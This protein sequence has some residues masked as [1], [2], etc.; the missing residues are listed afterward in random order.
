MPQGSFN[1]SR[2]LR[3]LGLKNII[4]MPVSE[5]IQ[6]VLP[7]ASMLGEVPVHVAG[8]A[9]FGGS[10]AQV[11][12][13]WGVLELQCL[14][15]G[16]AVLLFILQAAFNLQVRIEMDTTP[17]TWLTGPTALPPLNFT[18][19][20]TL[21]VANKGTR[22][23]GPSSIIPEFGIGFPAQDFGAFLIPRGS[24]LRLASTTANQVLAG[25]IAICGIAATEGGD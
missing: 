22:V 16:G 3:E 10:Q 19:N 25:S 20:P 12:A 9:I 6:P 1:I 18:A 11:A 8:A 21:S 15:P 4:E 24:F 13:E 14:D 23:A 5:T 7:L 2:L 17:T